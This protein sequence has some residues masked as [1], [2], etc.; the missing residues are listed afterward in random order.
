MGTTMVNLLANEELKKLQEM[1]YALDQFALTAILSAKGTI[2]D[3]ND[4]FLSVSG[5]LLEEIQRQSL[6][7]LLSE[8]FDGFFQEFLMPILSRGITWRGELCHTARNGVNFWTEATIVPIE[9]VNRIISHFHFMAF[10]VTERKT[11]ERVLTDNSAFVV[12]LMDLAPIGFFLADNAGNCTYINRKWTELS[13]LK[14]RRS[15]GMGWLEAVFLEDRPL[16]EAAWLRLINEDIVFNCEYRYRQADQSIVWIL[17]TAER[18]DLGPGSKTR[19]IRVEKD[20]T[21]R[22]Q[23]ESLINEQRA[24]I[25]SAARL[26]ALGEMAGGIAHEINNPLAILQ[27]QA[28][29]IIRLVKAETFNPVKLLTVA[30]NIRLT[31]E[32]IAAIVRS[33]LAIAREGRGDPF[34]QTQVKVLINNVLELCASRFTCNLIDLRLVAFAESL[35]VWCRSVEILQV[36]LNLLNNAFSAIDLLEEKWVEISVWDRQHHVEIWITDSGSGIPVELHDKLFQPFF[37]TKP[38][39]SGTGLGLSISRAVALDHRGDL[40]LDTESAHTRFI[41][42]LPKNLMNVDE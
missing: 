33:M 36:L 18:I 22:K 9:D 12:R 24:Q 32:R 13:G 28:R 2:I 27:L 4:K 30:E 29:Q 41:L 17:A 23:N 8:D 21:E 6:P 35:E 34:V 31:T 1:R 19:F 26:F 38:V 39:G 11:V 16:V 20:L 7:S 3:A 15:L 37:T 10:E 5:F 42:K 25:V 14:L 40:R